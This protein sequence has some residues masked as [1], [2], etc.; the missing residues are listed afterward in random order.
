MDRI[1]RSGVTCEAYVHQP[2]GDDARADTWLRGRVD[3]CARGRPDME[4]QCGIR[5]RSGGDRSGGADQWPSR[6]CSLS[7][8]VGTVPSGHFLG[9]RS[10]RLL[11]QTLLTAPAAS[12][13]GRPATKR[14]APAWFSR[15][16]GAFISE[17]PHV[18]ARRDAGS[19]PRRG[20]W[21]IA[22]FGISPIVVFLQVWDCYLLRSCP[23]HASRTRASS[24]LC[25]AGVQ[26]SSNLPIAGSPA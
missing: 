23:T 26:H 20:P 8:K 21:T 22:A 7:R 19:Y 3:D 15:A 11:V 10:A 17:S 9:L 12:A 16:T 1:A 14:K 25:A 6:K 4:R 18:Q 2:G 13:A 24:S 5:E